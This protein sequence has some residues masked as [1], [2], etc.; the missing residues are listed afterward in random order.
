MG[1]PCGPDFMVKAWKIPLQFNLRRCLLTGT[2]TDGYSKLREDVQYRKEVAE[3]VG[4]GFELS[5]KKADVVPNVP[6]SQ[7]AAATANAM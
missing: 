7:P 4:L 1:I 2:V 5:A 3:Q 6:S